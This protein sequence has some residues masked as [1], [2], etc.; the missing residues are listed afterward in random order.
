MFVFDIVFS[1]MRKPGPRPGCMDCS[2][3]PGAADNDSPF[4]KNTPPMSPFADI[5]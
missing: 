2:L 4:R 1:F 5:W 3:V